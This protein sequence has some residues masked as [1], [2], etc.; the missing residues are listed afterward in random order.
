[1]QLSQIKTYGFKGVRLDILAQLLALFVILRFVMFWVVVCLFRQLAS[2]VYA[3]MEAS[4]ADPALPPMHGLSWIMDHYLHWES[5]IPLEAGVLSWLAIVAGAV[6]LR[7]KIRLELLVAGAL[8][9]AC[10]AI[11]ICMEMNEP[12]QPGWHVTILPRLF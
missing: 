11:M 1:M 9:I 8:I 7:K 2:W 12:V 10:Y 6:L 5:M 4:L 3:E